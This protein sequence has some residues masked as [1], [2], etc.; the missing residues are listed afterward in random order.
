MI[1][2]TRRCRTETRPVRPFAA[3]PAQRTRLKVFDLALNSLPRRGTRPRGPPQQPRPCFRAHI[4]PMPHTRLPRSPGP[5]PRRSHWR[6]GGR[7]SGVAAPQAAVFG[8]FLEPSAGFVGLRRFLSAT[9]AAPLVARAVS[10]SFCIRMHP[11]TPSVARAAS[12][13]DA[14]TI[15]H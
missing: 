8:C 15:R 10:S 13:A 14:H 11:R 5:T 2:D 6:C 7:R 12:A 9:G 4:C 3:A 1:R